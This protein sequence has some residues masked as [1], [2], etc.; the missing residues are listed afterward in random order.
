[1]ATGFDDELLGEEE[2]TMLINLGKTLPILDG[3]SI[4]DGPGGTAQLRLLAPGKA[5]VLD[6][7]M[8]WSGVRVMM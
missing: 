8:S 5:L 3:L 2:M 7:L 4:F 6:H 1:M